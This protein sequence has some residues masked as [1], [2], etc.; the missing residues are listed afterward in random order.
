[1]TPRDPLAAALALVLLGLLAVVVAAAPV[2]AQ[3]SAWADAGP[4][5]ALLTLAA[6][7]DGGFLDEAADDA[8]SRGLAAEVAQ[9]GARLI[10]ADSLDAALARLE[11]VAQTALD[12]LA[13]AE[14]TV[15]EQASTLAAQAETIA[16][17]QAQVDGAITQEELIAAVAAAFD[18]GRREQAPAATERDE[19]AADVREILVR[20]G[21]PAAAA[22]R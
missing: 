9:R 14:A 10:V 7:D 19:I 18:Q 2:A 21:F 15:A 8:P 1:M 11:T 20:L 5:D 13:A 16:D 3:P 22:R 12:D 17:L 6:L 4:S